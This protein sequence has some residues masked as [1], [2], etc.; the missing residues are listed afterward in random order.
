MVQRNK[1]NA[2]VKGDGYA[3]GETVTVDIANLGGANSNI[4]GDLAFD[5]ATV[6]GNVIHNQ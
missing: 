3:V 5:V 1:C 6:T 4:S 2:N